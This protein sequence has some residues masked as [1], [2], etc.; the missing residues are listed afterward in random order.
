M[1]NAMDP[2]LASEIVRNYAQAATMIGALL[3]GVFGLWRYVRGERLRQT[4]LVRDFYR[5]FFESDRYKR[6]RFILENP[7]APEF[8]QLEAQLLEG[9]LPGDLEE[10][11]IDYLNFFE[12]VVGLMHRKM[13]PRRDVDWMFAFFLNRLFTTGFT[14]AYILKWGFEELAAECRRPERNPSRRT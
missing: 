4:E 9:G 14:R 12:F 2:L 11:F 7:D 13:V 10:P 6:I 3:A 5:M 1:M 8:A